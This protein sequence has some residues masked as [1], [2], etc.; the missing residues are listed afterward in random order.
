MLADTSLPHGSDASLSTVGSLS[1]ELSHRRITLTACPGRIPL[2]EQRVLSQLTLL[3]QSVK[4]LSR[5]T[6]IARLKPLDALVLLGAGPREAKPIHAAHL[7]A[8]MPSRHDEQRNHLFDRGAFWRTG[9]HTRR[10]QPMGFGKIA[11][12]AVVFRPS[13]RAT[14]DRQAQILE[15]LVQRKAGGV[16]CCCI[17]QG[18]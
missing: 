16:D 18:R 13:P 3:R 9:S 6:Q 1:Q 7:P 5:R 2:V 14:L 10:I 12:S 4:R 17:T 15:P 8:A 11:G